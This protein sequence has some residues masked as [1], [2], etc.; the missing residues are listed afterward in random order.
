MF[1]QATPRHMKYFNFA[2]NSKVKIFYFP[3]KALALF[4]EFLPLLPGGGKEGNQAQSACILKPAIL[5]LLEVFSTAALLRLV[6]RNLRLA[7]ST[8]G[9]LTGTRE[10]SFIIFLLYTFWQFYAK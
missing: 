3:V 5:S 9:C 2:L 10:K 1:Y 4:A 8:R 7:L 6:C